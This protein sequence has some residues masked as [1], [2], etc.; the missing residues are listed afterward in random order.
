MNAMTQAKATAQTAFGWCKR[1]R[2][3]QVSPP[4]SASRHP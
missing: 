3:M 2:F 4:V 1:A